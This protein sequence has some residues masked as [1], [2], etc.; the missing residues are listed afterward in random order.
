MT[1]NYDEVLR[2]VEGSDSGENTTDS[3]QPILPA[4]TYTAAVLDRPGENLRERTEAVR[5]NVNNLNFA[6]DYDRAFTLS[7]TGVFSVQQVSAGLYSLIATQ[8]ITITP[9]L[10]PGGSSGG[11]TGG[12]QLFVGGV[13][14]VGTQGVNDIECVA[15]NTTTGQRA[16]ADGET[17][18]DGQ[19]ISVG[20][21]DISLALIANSG[22][23]GGPGSVSIAVTGTPAR[24]VAIT[25]GTAGSGTQINDVLSV[26]NADRTSQGLY[27][28]ADLILLST[29]SPGTSTSVPTL[30]PTILQG[31]Y[32]AEAHVVT[33]SQLADFF[34]TTANLLKDKEGLAIG[35]PAGFVENGLRGSTR[36]GRRQALYDEPVNTV[37]DSISNVTPASGNN[38][39]NTGR[40]PEQIPGAIPIGKISD[41]AFVFIDGTTIPLP[42]SVPQ[43]TS[44]FYL[45][46]SPATLARLASAVSGYEGALLVGYDS[47]AAWNADRGSDIIATTVEG[48]LNEVQS[49]LANQVGSTS[50]ARCVGAEPLT[51][52]SSAGNFA[53]SLVA[54]SIRQ[55]LAAVVNA[56]GA[57]N[58]PGG[59]NS[60]VSEWGHTLQGYLPIYKDLSITSLAAQGGMMLSSNLNPATID[61]SDSITAPTALG[62]HEYEHLSLQTI[63][64]EGVITVANPV[65]WNSSDPHNNLRLT[66][67]SSGNFAVLVDLFPYVLEYAIGASSSDGLFC[68]TT[69]VIISGAVGGV[70]NN[71]LFILHRMVA[72]ASSQIALLRMDGSTPDFSSTNFTAGTLA[73]CNTTIKGNNSQYNREVRNHLGLY[74]PAEIE[75][76]A[77]AQLPYK[78]C[79]YPNLTPDGSGGAQA[80]I[81]GSEHSAANSI[82]YSYVGGGV[83]NTDHILEATDFALL[84][85]N[86]TSDPKNAN[87]SHIHSDGTWTG[88]TPSVRWTSGTSITVDGH[89]GI[90]LGG[91]LFGPSAAVT[92]TGLSSLT[93]DE[94]YYVYIYNNSGT[95][96]VGPP[97]TTPP[98]PANGNTFKTGDDEARYL[99]WFYTDPD[100]GDVLPFVTDC[101]FPI[102]PAPASWVG[103]PPSLQAY[104][105]GG[106]N[107]FVVGGNPG[108]SYLGAE[109]GYTGGS[110]VL[111][112]SDYVSLTAS[113]PF[114]VYAYL[115]A[116]NVVSYLVSTILPVAQLLPGDDSQKYRFVGA[117]YT[118]ASANIIPTW[119]NQEQDSPLSFIPQWVGRAPT[120]AWASATE[121]I[122]GAHPGINSPGNIPASF[123]AAATSGVSSSFPALSLSGSTW[124]YVY[125]FTVDQ[126]GTVN[127]T[128]ST[129]APSSASGYQIHP[130]YLNLLYVGCFRADPSANIYPF[131]MARGHYVYRWTDY[132]DVTGGKVVNHGTYYGTLGVGDSVVSLASFVPPHVSLVNF[133]SF[134]SSNVGGGDTFYIAPHGDDTLDIAL[135]FGIVNVGSTQIDSY[136]DFEMECESNEIDYTLGNS[137]G[138]TNLDIR[139]TGFSEP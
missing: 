60:R 41:G 49:D 121:V 86:E 39:I 124:Y 134:Y 25:F 100:T 12:A 98:D 19:T 125:A 53:L 57:A 67:V 38:L 126:D 91:K 88:I 15:S 14:G 74:W 117:F 118:D 108:L 128:A 4:E 24:H 101:K 94:I 54:G 65:T 59:T 72:S 129:T 44:T 130:T 135:Q 82:W 7:S 37:G 10:T 104:P 139:V 99:G 103:N 96:Q 136:N 132:S 107:Y 114:Y 113:A 5:T 89:D 73:F 84:N 115:S 111:A 26:V 47:H 61:L 131:R 55:Q 90:T 93:A 52:T 87:T 34:T 137:N 45:G 20:A 105:D 123:T 116:N 97:V 3:I 62:R 18:A 119:L 56:A 133:R 66:S 1:M 71:G 29:T 6:A 127:Y 21:N 110:G 28:A 69:V 43:I 11:R 122:V 95:L 36:G 77:A 112:A 76:C 106:D 63:G 80:A 35:Y 79:Y 8:N 51:G 138:G 109:S 9:T 78:G 85:G 83:R 30:S 23:D 58:A 120:L 32:D 22:L 102:G 13:V 81:K 27:G 70:D 75:A 42:P 40:V 68:P 31:G 92:V 50:G 2:Y 46:E 17:L 48:A 33:P 16:Y 64:I